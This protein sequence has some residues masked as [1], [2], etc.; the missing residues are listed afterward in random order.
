MNEVFKPNKNVVKA[1][2]E[3]AFNALVE[4]VVEVAESTDTSFNEVLVTFPSEFMLAVVLGGIVFD[5]SDRI[6]TN[7]V[8]LSEDA[9]RHLEECGVPISRSDELP[10]QRLGRAVNEDVF[11]WQSELVM[12]GNTQDSISGEKITQVRKKKPRKKYLR[13]ESMQ[14]G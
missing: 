2:R 12:N 3:P 1:L 11:M 4:E 14:L 8:I 5:N 13:S 9:A 10:G 7:G 6:R